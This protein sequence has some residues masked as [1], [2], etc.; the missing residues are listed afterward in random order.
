MEEAVVPSFPAL[1]PLRPAM[2]FHY[3]FH[4]SWQLHLNHLLFL[5]THL[6]GVMLMASS[7][8]PEYEQVALVLLCIVVAFLIAYCVLLTRPMFLY[9]LSY[10]VLVLLPLAG[11]AWSLEQTLLYGWHHQ[12][13]PAFGHRWYFL[14]LVGFGMMMT[15]FTLQVIGHFCFEE[16][17]AKPNLA[18]GFIA[19][20]VLEYVSMWLRLSRCL[21]GEGKEEEREERCCGGPNVLRGLFQEVDRR[22]EAVRRAKRGLLEAE[23]F[24]SGPPE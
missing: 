10:S 20:P 8:P 5:H 16:F 24:T 2:V 15:S 13:D 12:H 17:Q 7:L 3:F 9:G 22:R 23:T 11:A 6:L 4:H 14:T 21:R 1:G 18:H 19:A